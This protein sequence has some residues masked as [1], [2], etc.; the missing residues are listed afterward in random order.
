MARDKRG[1]VD[2][3]GVEEALEEMA[4]E[5]SSDFVAGPTSRNEAGDIRRAA[6]KA[7]G[8][9][10]ASKKVDPDLAVDPAGDRPKSGS[11]AGIHSFQ[12]VPPDEGGELRVTRSNEDIAE[13]ANVAA[14]K[15]P[16][17][18]SAQTDAPTGFGQ[19]GRHPA[20]RERE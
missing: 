19:V 17:P 13:E 5:E 20:K 16:A 2:E 1:Q 9:M 8:V 14:R 11:R 15:S 7:T 12:D 10:G 18:L 3:L 4:V 6:A